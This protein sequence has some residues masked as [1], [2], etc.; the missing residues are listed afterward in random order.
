[1][2]PRSRRTR[3]AAPRLAPFDVERQEATVGA[4]GV[5]ISA[6]RPRCCAEPR[7]H[8]APLHRLH[9]ARPTPFDGMTPHRGPSGRRGPS[10][11]AH[12]DVLR[13][14]R[15]GAA[16]GRRPPADRGRRGGR[17]LRRSDRADDRSHGRQRSRRPRPAR[18]GNRRDPSAIPGQPVSSARRAVEQRCRARAHR[19][20][21]TARRAC[22]APSPPR[23]RATRELERRAWNCRAP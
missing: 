15:R 5:W 17:A 14:G 4:T 20:A 21:G 22:V 3:L 9:R 18:P 19:A 16:G 11:R 12:A 6:A 13:P 10:R 2:T 7:V 8:R 1:M 23:G